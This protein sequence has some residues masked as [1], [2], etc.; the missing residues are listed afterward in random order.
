M[1]DRFLYHQFTDISP[2][3]PTFWCPLQA[4][5]H[6]FPN[7]QAFCHDGALGAYCLCHLG[8]RPHVPGTTKFAWTVPLHFPPL[9]LVFSFAS[10][11]STPVTSNNCTWPPF[12]WRHSKTL[13]EVSARQRRITLGSTSS[14]CNDNRPGNGE[15][16]VW[17][18][19]YS[20]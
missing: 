7:F 12:P 11:Y 19:F 20:L 10:L 13:P 16:Y 8:P 9:L 4:L 1:I 2:Q 15:V 17:S 18:M 14:P 6:L 3:Q 5:Y